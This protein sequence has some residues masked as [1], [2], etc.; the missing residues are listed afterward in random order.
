MRARAVIPSKAILVAL[1]PKMRAESD[2]SHRYKAVSLDWAA[3]EQ[4]KTK[5]SNRE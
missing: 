5:L 2:V 3:H 1:L 4:Y